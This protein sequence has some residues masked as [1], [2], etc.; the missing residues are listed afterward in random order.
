VRGH[1][2]PAC[3]QCE[4][5]LCLLA[6]LWYRLLHQFAQTAAGI[7]PLASATVDFDVDA[8]QVFA[9]ALDFALR[10]IAR[11][12]GA[13]VL[14]AH[15]PGID[16]PGLRVFDAFGGQHAGRLQTEQ[17]GT[18][19]GNGVA[20]CVHARAQRRQRAIEFADVGAELGDAR[21][22]GQFAEVEFV[23][24]AEVARS[25]AFAV[26]AVAGDPFGAR[27]AACA[28]GLCV[29]TRC[30]RPS[31]SA[32]QRGTDAREAHH[33]GQRSPRGGPRL[34]VRHD[35]V[36]EAR[37]LAQRPRGV[38]VGSRSS[39]I[40]WRYGRNT[41]SSAACQAASVTSTTSDSA[42]C[43][44]PASVSLAR[45]ATHRRRPVRRG[46]RAQRAA[47]RSFPRSATSA[48]SSRPAS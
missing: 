14:L 21:L 20:C 30:M 44:M 10:V 40:R 7:V 31:R 39:S 24:P 47:L 18:Q 22:P 28:R 29:S 23:R 34:R 17:A 46:V 11:R 19:G 33:F 9:S 12:F 37:A 13:V 45:K 42:Q 27:A 1:A 36:A 25:A 43:A 5:A 35:E 6:A 4:H 3:A 16:L 2:A 26:I 41:A 8:A 32:S 48:R 38:A 15:A